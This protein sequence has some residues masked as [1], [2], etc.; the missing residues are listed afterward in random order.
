[1]QANPPLFRMDGDMPEMGWWSDHALPTESSRLDGRNSPSVE[2]LGINGDSSFI[3]ETR[4]KVV[5]VLKNIRPASISALI[6]W[7]H[8]L[9]WAIL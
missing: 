6:E 2:M 1:M 7:K 9:V 5:L 4:V 8:Q 3:V